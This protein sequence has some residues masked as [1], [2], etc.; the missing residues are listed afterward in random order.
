MESNQTVTC[1]R[2]G[3]APV[4]YLQWVI[5]YTAVQFAFYGLNA[6]CFLT[7]AYC[8]ISRGVRGSRPRLGLLAATT[9]MFIGSTVFVV[10]DTIQSMYGARDA[11]GT[12]QEH[13]CSRLTRLSIAQN[14]VL[15]MMFMLSDVIV[16]WR[17]WVLWSANRIVRRCLIVCLTLT[18]SCLLADAAVVAWEQAVSYY[19]NSALFSL[20]VTL[21]ILVTNV[22]VTTTIGVRAIAHY[23]AMRSNIGSREYGQKVMRALLVLLWSGAAY[24]ALCFV[25]FASGVTSNHGRRWGEFVGAIGASVSCTYPTLI[26][27]WAA[28]ERDNDT[29]VQLQVMQSHGVQLTEKVTR[30]NDDGRLALKSRQWIGGSWPKTPQMRPRDPEIAVRVLKAAPT[31]PP[32]KRTFPSHFL[33]P[34]TEQDS[35]PY[36]RQR[37]TVRMPP[38]DDSGPPVIPMAG[39]GHNAQSEWPQDPHRHW[40]NMWLKAG[41]LN[42][43]RHQ[44]Q[45][46]ARADAGAPPQAQKHQP[47]AQEQAAAPQF[48]PFPGPKELRDMGNKLPGEAA[49]EQAPA[50][51]DP[52]PRT[53]PFLSEAEL[54]AEGYGSVLYRPP[55]NHR[56]AAP[57][58]PI[59][60][61]NS[62]AAAPKQPDLKPNFPPRGHIT[63]TYH[64]AP[65]PA[66]PKY[67]DDPTPYPG[68][69]PL[70]KTTHLNAPPRVAQQPFVPFVPPMPAKSEKNSVHVP[71][72]DHRHREH[73]HRDH[74]HRDHRHHGHRRHGH[75]RDGGDRREARAGHHGKR[76]DD[77]GHR[78]GRDK[79][80]RLER[81]LPGPDQR[82]YFYDKQAPH[83]SFTNFSP[84][85]VRYKGK[86]YPTSEHLYHAFKFMKHKPYLAEHIRTC[87][88]EPRRALI[89]ARRFDS[90]KRRD[91]EDKKIE[92][93][94]KALWYK[95]TQRLDLWQELVNTGDAELVED[96]P[97]DWF[98]GIGQDRKGRNELGK[99]LMRLRKVLVGH[100]ATKALRPYG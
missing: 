77:D 56:G 6:V 41:W 60:K 52:P 34:G 20:L 92:K 98:W 33:L 21:P 27:I 78:N 35:D 48:T 8:L 22:T 2:A 66:K 11:F 7:S 9:V 4:E 10:L 30:P 5:A 84:H 67:R 57:R 44:R 53:T 18:C 89:E 94:E 71:N 69:T 28:L 31:T 15:R 73:R 40:G 95:F 65:L 26:I 24:C 37:I 88:S 45:P 49:E 50:A 90:E 93:M 59:L 42:P 19:A 3:S 99:A 51:A 54:R 25:F 81:R 23:R 64:H 86:R 55:P 97:Y 16:V 17:A 32:H 87:S 13:D 68:T 91:W 96:S 100:P 14:V 12:L 63:T 58:R 61:N 1:A 82:I 38:R 36:L 79:G 62:Q 39:F 47:A 76:D 72:D 70:P 29:E 85:S 80:R 43:R 75:H 83:Y 74:R 46:P